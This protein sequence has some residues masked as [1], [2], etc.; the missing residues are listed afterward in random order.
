[1]RIIKSILFALIAFILLNQHVD[2]QKKQATVRSKYFHDDVAL[3][4]F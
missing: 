4:D 3:I 1:M 2:G